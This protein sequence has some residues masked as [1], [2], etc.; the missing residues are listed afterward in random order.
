MPAEYLTSWRPSAIIAAHN[1]LLALLDA[2][3][4]PAKMTAHDASD[5][6]LA[7]VTLGD[8][9]GVVNGTTGLL[10]LTIA[11]QEESAPAGGNVS[12]WT[13]RDGAGVAYRSLEAIESTT[14]VPGKITMNTVAVLAGGPV[15]ILA[16]S[17]G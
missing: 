8:P 7:T 3:A 14:P 11:A 1:A 16:A 10:T 2:D 4:L 12:Y 17:V 6:L 9:A 15:Q 13:I 5:T